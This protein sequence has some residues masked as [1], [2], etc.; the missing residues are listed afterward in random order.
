MGGK[1]ECSQEDA[2]RKEEIDQTRNGTYGARVWF[3]QDTLR[4]T[5]GSVM[6]NIWE[7]F[8]HW[9]PQMRELGPQSVYPTFF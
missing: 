5:T 4:E 6:G 2:V 1:R 8:C 3:H 9:L 7:V